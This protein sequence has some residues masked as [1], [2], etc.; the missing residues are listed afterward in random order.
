MAN[1]AAAGSGVGPMRE[2]I[3]SSRRVSKKLKV[4]AP[5]RI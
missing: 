5:M 4:N 3:G 1:S 2:M